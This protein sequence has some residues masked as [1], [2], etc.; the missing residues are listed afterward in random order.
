M[1][2]RDAV[3]VD[4]LAKGAIK[5]HHIHTYRLFHQGLIA[6]LWLQIFL[7]WIKVEHIVNPSIHQP[8]TIIQACLWKSQCVENKLFLWS[9]KLIRVGV[10]EVDWCE[11]FDD[12]REWGG[13]GVYGEEE[14]WWWLWGRIR[15]LRV[16][17]E[18]L[19]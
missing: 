7:L 14:G 18:R 1:P 8:Q 13:G 4:I 19:I 11:G 3:R 9:L 5:R 16:I 6:Y 17:R 2:I 12:G 15:R 10:F